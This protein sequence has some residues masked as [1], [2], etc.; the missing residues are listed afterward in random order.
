MAYYFYK[1]FTVAVQ[2]LWKFSAIPMDYEKV[3]KRNLQGARY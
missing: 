3:I 1:H 2:E